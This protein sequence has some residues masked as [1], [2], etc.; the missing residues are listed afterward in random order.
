[1]GEEQMLLST[2]QPVS[3]QSREF[4]ATAAPVPGSAGLITVSSPEDSPVQTSPRVPNSRI[5]QFNQPKGWFYCLP[6]FR[7]AF[8]P[9]PNYS[10]PKEKL[11]IISG[12]ADLKS[13]KKF[14]VFDQSGDQTTVMVSSGPGTS[15]HCMTSWT[16]NQLSRSAMENGGCVAKPDSY[17]VSRPVP[18]NDINDNCDDADI[19]SEM[20]EDT[21]E[22]NALLYSDDEDGESYDSDDDEVVSTGHSPSMLTAH[23]RT[24]NFQRQDNEVAAS[25]VLPKKRK[26]YADDAEA[27]DDTANSCNINGRKNYLSSDADA[28]Y[29]AEW[30]ISVPRKIDLSSESKRIQTEKIR[31]T[32]ELL[33]D[34]VPVCKGKNS[35]VVLDEAIHYLKSL[36]VK[37]KALG[38]SAL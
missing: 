26:W 35:I 32:V 37:A 14:L 21:E 28:K 11:P 8:T 30:D 20:H 29:R 2:Q 23:E 17:P 24:E 7:Q 18:Q 3:S 16:L 25:S 19:M 38:L 31:E 4:N 22:L 12:N 36:K 5:G 10:L 15:F 27:R 9:G 34:M 6:R 13:E 33:Q 1:M